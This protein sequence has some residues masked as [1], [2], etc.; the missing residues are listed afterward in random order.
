VQHSVFVYSQE[1]L[2]RAMLCFFEVYATGLLFTRGSGGRALAGCGSPSVNSRRIIDSKSGLGWIKQ[3]QR[4]WFAANAHSVM[5]A[6][7]HSRANLLLL[8]VRLC[9]LC[10]IYVPVHPSGSTITSR[11][12]RQGYITSGS[13]NIRGLSMRASCIG[14][15]RRYLFSCFRCHANAVMLRIHWEWA[16]S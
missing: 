10:S 13:H 8:L 2:P 5:I 15:I 7:L 4:C 12:P 16:F 14:F 9:M 3:Q 11:S 1:Y 6:S